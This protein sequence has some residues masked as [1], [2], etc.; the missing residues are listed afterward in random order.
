V[1]GDDF[2]L[3]SLVAGARTGIDRNPG[4][5]SIVEGR[6]IKRAGDRRVAQARSLQGI[7]FGEYEQEAQIG[8]WLVR[9]NGVLTCGRKSRKLDLGFGSRVVQSAFLWAA[10]TASASASPGRHDRVA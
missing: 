1:T 5:H 10:G 2:Y 7:V 8:I 3:G 6:L 9:D 4:D